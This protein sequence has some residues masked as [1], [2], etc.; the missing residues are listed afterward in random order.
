[1]RPAARGRRAPARKADG[2]GAAPEPRRGVSVLALLALLLAALGTAARAQE[3]APEPKVTP[4]PTTPP[5]NAATTA[6]ATAPITPP[7]TAPTTAPTTPAAPAPTPDFR[8]LRTPDGSR[9]I[10]VPTSGPRVVHWVMA[11]PAGVVE[12]PPG[13]EG[14]SFA[15][16]RAALAG[17]GVSGSRRSEREV[18]LLAWLNQH[19]EAIA[20][21]R[22][23]GMPLP[24]NALVELEK[25]RLEAA[26]L[27][28]SLAWQR[29]LRE[30]PALGPDLTETDDGV[31]L[32]VTTSPAGVPS[33]GR[34]L[35]ERREGKVIRDIHPHL[36]AVREEAQRQRAGVRGAL[37][38]E[39]L[40]LAFL[41]HRLGAAGATP[42]PVPLMPSWEQ[43]VTLWQAT[44]HP[45]RTCHVL[46]GGF[47]ADRVAQALEVTFA[48]TAMVPPSIPARPA[49]SPEPIE[50]RTELRGQE[51]AALAIAYSVPPHTA[52]HELA[53]L[54]AWLGGDAESL[55]PRAMRRAGLEG[56]T[57]E[58][59]A[60]FPT[61]AGGL[62]LIEIEA[63]AAAPA[64]AP[65]PAP[66]AAPAAAPDARPEADLAAIVDAALADAAQAGPSAADTAAAEAL[67]QAHASAGDGGD[68]A[69][70]AEIA[71]QCGL[72]GRP[73]EEV[74]RPPTVMTRG[75]L[76]QLAQRTLFGGRAVARATTTP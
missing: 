76:H 27:A 50:R 70:A 67:V 22:A 21:A 54:A 39:L 36:R 23:A 40:A 28:D 44:Q 55:L 34:L 37:R 71:A 63:P 72:C 17:T 8:E 59:S 47:D 12:D 11:T 42:A 56:T 33:V 62:L 19:E 66:A 18:R 16:A 51:H 43:A 48:A 41:G 73:V 7:T 60:P 20:R 69:L 3:V 64:A 13:L 38:R 53:V 61:A 5:T 1:M 49:P 25:V 31:L 57:V 68:A 2:H 58:T 74:L 29:A 30:V 32:H 26:S 65:A 4:E 24:A 45:S 10:L 15:V 6:P 35:V 14:L 75:D 9:F 46:V 52:P